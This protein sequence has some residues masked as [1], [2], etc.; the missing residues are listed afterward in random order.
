MTKKHD[1]NNHSFAHL[2]LMLLLHLLVKCRSS[3]LAVYNNEFIGNVC[4]G[5]DQGSKS[6]GRTI[7]LSRRRFETD[8]VSW[9]SCSIWKPVFSLFFQQ[10]S[11]P[12]H[13]AAGSR[14][15][16]LFHPL[17]GRLT[18]LTS[19]RLTSDYTLCGVCLRSEYVESVVPKSRRR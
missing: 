19:T 1:V 11:A 2:T 16:I 4:I 8:A 13:R 18:Y 10:D 5:S 14:R 17:S 7:V 12:P 3:S 9:H 15:P 6:M